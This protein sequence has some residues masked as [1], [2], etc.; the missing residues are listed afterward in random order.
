MYGGG[1][2]WREASVHHGLFS[3]KVMDWV[4]SR[5]L[6]FVAS[7]RHLVP[8]TG[9]GHVSVEKQVVG[10][11]GSVWAGHLL[12]IYYFFVSQKALECRLHSNEAH[13]PLW[14]PILG[15]GVQFTLPSPTP[16]LCASSA[17]GASGPQ[18][19]LINLGFP[20]HIFPDSKEQS[21][22]VS[23]SRKPVSLVAGSQKDYVPACLPLASLSL[24]ARLALCTA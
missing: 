12:L 22:P 9:N 11:S 21:G 10:G 6:P 19:R 2:L 16:P 14:I 7:L 24:G 18:H 23:L 8:E 1:L 3:E 13:E 15:G 5:A 20:S 17:G 4:S